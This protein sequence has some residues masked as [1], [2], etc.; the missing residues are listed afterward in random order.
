MQ[1]PLLELRHFKPEDASPVP[2]LPIW[3]QLG[4]VVPFAR[5]H[6]RRT[7]PE[8]PPPVIVVPDGRW[9]PAVPGDRAQKRLAAL[10]IASLAIHVSL[11]A[12]LWRAPP[13]L[14]GIELAPITVEIVVSDGSPGTSPNVGEQI[15]GQQPKEPEVAQ[16][17]PE[18]APPA[19]TP[20]EDNAPAVS[21]PAR[22]PPAQDAI[23]PQPEQPI[24]KSDNA[25][26]ENKAPVASEPEQTQA[27]A[28]PEQLRQTEAAP[29]PEPITPPPPM[30]PQQ[31]PPETKA[32]PVPPPK[33]TPLQPT[34]API[35]RQEPARDTKQP[36]Q[37]APTRRTENGAKQNAGHTTPS[38]AAPAR[39]SAADP[40]YSGTVFAHLA[41][42]K[43]MPPEAQRNHSQGTAVVNFVIDGSGHVGA[44]RLVRATGI[45]S[46][47]Q[48]A[49]A[50]P[51]RASPFP[52]PP[53]GRSVPVNAPISFRF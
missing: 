8:P 13:P 38:A 33:P 37:A 22:E 29:Q 39:R 24:V 28:N 6:A 7:E 41:R 43:R 49:Q 40:N 10:L 14:P 27:P 12:L 35:R 19:D 3:A 47:D 51:R 2:T 26:V 20:I 48:E 46:L 42:F 50:M 44:V 31:V 21:E 16:S 18:T 11:L 53:G 23:P 25:P 52:P 34:A 15:P 5:P 45:A 9:A 4:N 36:T 30:Q 32:A 1:A 17:R